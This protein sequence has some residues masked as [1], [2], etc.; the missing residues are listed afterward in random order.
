MVRY[1]PRGI[2]RPPSHAANTP[3]PH[4]DARGDSAGRWLGVARELR[5]L[6]GRRMWPEAFW[7]RDSTLVGPRP[8]PR[9]Q[10][11]AL[12]GTAGFSRVGAPAVEVL[13]QL[14]L[15]DLQ[16]HPP[17]WSLT[18]QHPVVSAS[19]AGTEQH[20][21][22]HVPPCGVHLCRWCRQCMC[23]DPRARHTRRE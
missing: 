14:K 3:C 7:Q 23:Q 21:G 13:L 1:K 2:G 15:G 9:L 18:T 8:A 11:L 16:R 22:T 12:P 4:G 5:K 10:F 20:L 6:K 17:T 19:T